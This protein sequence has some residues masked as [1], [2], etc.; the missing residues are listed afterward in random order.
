MGAR[1]IFY[2]IPDL[3][4]SIETLIALCDRAR[5]DGPAVLEGAYRKLTPANPFERLVRIGLALI[6]D[7]VDPELVSRTLEH[8]S[9]S[10]LT[11]LQYRWRIWD[12]LLGAMSPGAPMAPLGEFL[13]ALL[14]GDHPE[15]SLLRTA[16]SD[17]LTELSN[18]QGQLEW[19]RWPEEYR[20]HPLTGAGLRLAALRS[21]FPDERLRRALDNQFASYKDQF[22][23][24]SNIAIEGVISLQSG[25]SPRLMRS[26]LST[27]EGS[28]IMQVRTLAED[29]GFESAG[30]EAAL[31]IGDP[32]S[33]DRMFA[34][35]FEE[36]FLNMDFRAIRRVMRE[37]E[38]GELAC[39]LAGVR[40]EVR[41]IILA[42]LSDRV[43]DRLRREAG[44]GKGATRGEVRNAQER[45]LGVFQRLR[46]S[47]E[48]A[49]SEA[50]ES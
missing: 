44:A 31:Q 48:I 9:E 19:S 10:Y 43:V 2:E 29:Q 11:R 41:E 39:A 50:D 7:G 23:K 16:F 6:V 49:S 46:E 20:R 32:E 24:M 30:D 15:N 27:L 34:S 18:E 13:E 17:L 14:L 37:V 22:I 21:A 26:L 12:G 42:N 1:R 35:S 40:E 25:D 3:N 33:P 8:S 47:G 36:V 5:Q 4:E 38:P 45:I 28:D